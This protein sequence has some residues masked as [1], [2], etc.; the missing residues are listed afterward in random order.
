MTLNHEFENKVPVKFME[1]IRFRRLRLRI[2]QKALA[3]L[4]GTT[5]YTVSEWELEKAQ[6]RPAMR[7][8]L[9]EWLGFDP[10]LLA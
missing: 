1:H 3:K 8:K 7:R 2:T 5:L 10:D 6:P 9:V 4:I